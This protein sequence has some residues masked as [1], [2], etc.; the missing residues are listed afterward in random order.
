MSEYLGTSRSMAA[1]SSASGSRRAL[2]DIAQNT[3]SAVAS[4]ILFVWHW[5]ERANDDAG[6][7]RN[8]GETLRVGDS[9]RAALESEVRPMRD[10]LESRRRRECSIENPAGC[11]SRLARWWNVRWLQMKGYPDPEGTLDWYD[12]YKEWQQKWQASQPDIPVTNDLFPTGE[13]RR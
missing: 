13:R 6:A 10:R 4:A 12:E 7:A 2:C 9:E 5:R 3:S 1:A 11:I 8:A